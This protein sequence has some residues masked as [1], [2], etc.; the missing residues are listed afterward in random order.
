M[1]MEKKYNQMKSSFKHP[2]DEIVKTYHEM[3]MLKEVYEYTT[4]QV[5][6]MQNIYRDLIKKCAMLR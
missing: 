1:E 6:N 3:E 4:E 5:K 2:Y